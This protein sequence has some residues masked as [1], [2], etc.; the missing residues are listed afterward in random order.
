M[1][2]M[3]LINIFSVQETITYLGKTAAERTP[4]GVRQSIEQEG[5]Y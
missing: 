4:M 5:I 2:F 3:F 1:T